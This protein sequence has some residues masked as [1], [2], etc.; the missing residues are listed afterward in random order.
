MDRLQASACANPA[1][2]M[3]NSEAMHEK[4]GKRQGIVKEFP[5]RLTGCL[6]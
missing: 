5:M 1:R 2:Q 3:D 6:P 4:E